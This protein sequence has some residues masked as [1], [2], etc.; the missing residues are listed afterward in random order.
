VANFVTNGVISDFVT[1]NHDA[2]QTDQ[3]TACAEAATG[4]TADNF[5]SFVNALHS[6]S[7][8]S[9][10]THYKLKYANHCEKD[11]T[12]VCPSDSPSCF[13]HTFVNNPA[14]NIYV[15]RKQFADAA[16][17]IA[18]GKAAMDIKFN[19]DN[20]WTSDTTA[21][22]GL[23]LITKHCYLIAITASGGGNGTISCIIKGNGAIDS[24]DV[25]WTRSIDFMGLPSWVCSSSVTDTIY[26]AG[27]C[28]TW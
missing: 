22:I 20:N 2:A 17:D 6:L 12:L 10:K 14:Y 16:A 21:D 7:P 8:Q 3:F 27:K 19:K 24:K 1:Y 9:G 28:N 13:S 15:T 4:I 26:T 25:T 18:A 23:P 11:N 5:N